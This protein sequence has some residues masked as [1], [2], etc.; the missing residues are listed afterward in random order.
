[1]ALLEAYQL[2]TVSLDGLRSFLDVAQYLIKLGREQ[3]ERSEDTAVRSEIVSFGQLDVTS[4]W[5]RQLTV[6]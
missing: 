4:V 2:V 5:M 6:S 3:I 1:M